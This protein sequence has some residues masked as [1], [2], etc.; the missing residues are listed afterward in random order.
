MKPGENSVYEGFDIE[1][2]LEEIDIEYYPKF[3]ECLL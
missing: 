1:K 2:V 3:R